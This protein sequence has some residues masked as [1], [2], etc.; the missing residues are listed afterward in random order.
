M[1]KMNQTK[2]A[3]VLTV[4][5]PGMIGHFAG[6]EWVPPRTDVDPTGVGRYYRPAVVKMLDGVE[7]RT[8]SGQSGIA[9]QGLDDT[10]QF[11]RV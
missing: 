6:A 9:D 8:S 2:T 4:V 11:Y 1:V 7:T 3:T 5:A 10:G